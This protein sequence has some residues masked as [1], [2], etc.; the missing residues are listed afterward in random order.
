MRSLLDREWVRQ[1]G[2]RQVP[3]RPAL[4]ST[5]HKFLEYFGLATLD[6]LPEL[7]DPREIAQIM[8]ELDISGQFSAGTDEINEESASGQILHEAASAVYS[9]AKEANVDSLKLK[10]R[11]DKEINHASNIEPIDENTPRIVVPVGK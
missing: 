9:E 3:G 11:S 10:T 8:R 7:D 2:F 1:S 6:D 5:T 4:Y